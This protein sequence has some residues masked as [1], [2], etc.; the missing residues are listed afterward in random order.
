M[1]KVKV[2]EKFCVGYNGIG[3]VLEMDVSFTHYREP[4]TDGVRMLVTRTYG[5]PEE[6]IFPRG[7]VASWRTVLEHQ[8]REQAAEEMGELAKQVAQQLNKLLGKRGQM[9][10][11]IFIRLLEKG[12]HGVQLKLTRAAFELLAESFLG[13]SLAREEASALAELLGG[14]GASGASALPPGSEPELLGEGTTSEASAQLRERYALSS[15]AGPA[16]SKAATPRVSPPYPTLQEW[17]NQHLDPLQSH[18]AQTPAW[19]QQAMWVRD[20]LHNA[21]M[22]DYEARE[23]SPVRVISTHRSKSQLLPVYWLSLPEGGSVI[24][25]GNFHNWKLS[26]DTAGRELPSHQFQGLIQADWQTSLPYCEGFDPAWVYGS[27]QAD[28]GLFTVELPSYQ[29]AVWCF[30]F[31][32]TRGLAE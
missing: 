17:I 30:A 29:E 21:L 20:R 27:F 19:L 16:L 31:L 2:G 24:T 1:G 26:V 9:D 28:P 7:Q 18:P 5:T 8:S 15:P 23:C 22:P 12:K 32:L 10:H 13:Q 6:K 25:R 11:D 3:E 14:E 4:R